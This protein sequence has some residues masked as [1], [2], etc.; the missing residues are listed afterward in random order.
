MTHLLKRLLDFL[1]EPCGFEIEWMTGGFR[2][3][4]PTWTWFVFFA[5]ILVGMFLSGD[6]HAR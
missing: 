1:T 6:H 2:F 3:A 5:L 4:P